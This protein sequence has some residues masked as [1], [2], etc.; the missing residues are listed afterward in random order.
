MGKKDSDWRLDT[1]GENQEV[2]Y[3]GRRKD[4]RQ[5]QDDVQNAFDQSRKL[6]HIVGKKD[7]Q[8]KDENRATECDS[9]RIEEGVPVHKVTK[10]SG[11]IAPSGWD[12]QRRLESRSEADSFEDLHGFCALEIFKESLCCICVL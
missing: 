2:A 11:R 9:K 6:R 8:K 5:R 3:N 4:Q 1:K 12:I 10:A 7:P